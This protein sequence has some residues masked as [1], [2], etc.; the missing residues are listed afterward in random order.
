MM[1]AELAPALRATDMLRGSEG[2]DH[3]KAWVQIQAATDAP[4][5]R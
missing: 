3:V 1:Y 5:H 2:L 4:Q